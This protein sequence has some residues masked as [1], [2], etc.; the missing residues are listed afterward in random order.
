MKPSE[1]SLE[2]FK[3]WMDSQQQSTHSFSRPN[4]N[5]IGT[6]VESKVSM[7]KFA[8]KMNM[9]SGDIDKVISEFSE[10]GGKIADIEDKNFLIETTSGSFIIHKYYVRRRT[11]E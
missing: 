9:E 5:L 4:D 3:K 8:S 7:K 2:D 11:T 6:M 1:I 10:S